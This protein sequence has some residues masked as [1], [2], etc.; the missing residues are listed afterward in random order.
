MGMIWRVGDGVGLNIW[1]EP[2]IPRDSGRKPFTLRGHHIITEVAELINP[3]TR[4]WDELL[5]RDIFW[6]EDAEV[7]LALP[8][9]QG[10]S[11]MVA[12]HYDKHGVFSVKS[13]YKVARDTY[14]RNH[15][16]Q[17][18]QGGSNPGPLSLWK[19]VWKLS[20][21]NKIKHFLWRFLHNSHPLRDNLIRRGM[22][23]V[24][25]C[26]VC[27]QV[28]EDGGHLF[29]KC[30]MARQVWELLG[31]STER[32]V[33][34]NFYT[35]IDVVEFILRASES[36]NLM[37]IV[38]LWYT[39]SERNAIREE[40]RRRSPQTLARC[41][42]LYVQEMRTTETT[43][44]PTAN[45]EQQQYKWSKPPVDI[46]KLNC[47]GSF[48]PETRAGSWG[49]LIRDHE[50]DVIMSGRGRVNHLMTPMQAELIACLQGVQ[51]AANLG[52]G[53]LILETDALEV[54]KAIKTSAYNYA[55]VGYLVEEIK[56]L[57]ELNFISVE[58]VFACR[59]CNRAAH[60]LAA[61]GLA[62]NEGEE[63]FTNSL[64]QSVSVIVADD[65][66]AE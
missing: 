42:E 8:V 19:R 55:A 43:A 53:R 51:L 38:A 61:L 63:E 39:W 31:L 17:G 14:I 50:G 37:M 46:L 45:Q 30:G 24:P 4:Q 25:R 33:L 57:I 44:N 10:R 6:E 48:S 28:G 54:V 12:W 66:S 27:N 41:V 18:Q 7:I 26:P 35:P 3:V 59:I 15:T 64:P 29:F 13:A 9:Y 52:I 21:P 58:C 20:C 60:E 62:C 11:N 32:E 1:S 23:I 16:S 47:D 34:A 22:E 2:W 5:V 40:D 36:R 49:V 56:S 65:L